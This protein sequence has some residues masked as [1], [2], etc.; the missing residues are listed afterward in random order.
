MRPLRDRLSKTVAAFREQ[1]ELQPA[2]ILLSASMLLTVY[3]YYGSAECFERGL[4]QVLGGSDLLP[5]YSVLYSFFSCFVLLGLVPFVLIKTVLKKKVREFGWQ[6]GKWK[7][8]LVI[9]GVLFPISALLLIPTSQMP[10]FRGEYPLFQDA[11]EKLPIAMLIVYELCYALYYFG[12]ESFFRGYM[13]FGLKDSLGTVNAILI[14]T[15]PS[16]L[17]HIGK[18]DAEIF[19]AIVAGIVFGAIALRT[20]SFIY[21]FLLHWLIGVT[22]D[23]CIVLSAS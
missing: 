22:L 21:V 18:P 8:G 10:S 20:R 13:L 2:L 14:Q 4:G 9:V 17:L 12:W 5:L 6:P 7:R 15:I 23:V 19:A 16:T 11:G 1:I 3:R